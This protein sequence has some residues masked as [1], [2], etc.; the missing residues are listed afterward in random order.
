MRAYSSL[1]GWDQL[2][3]SGIIGAMPFWTQLNDEINY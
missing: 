3:N 1:V 2:E